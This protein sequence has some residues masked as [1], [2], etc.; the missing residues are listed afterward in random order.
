MR[1]QREV[2]PIPTD[3]GAQLA[4]SRE[5]ITHHAGCDVHWREWAGKGNGTP[6]VALHGGHGS[7]LHWLRNIDTFSTHRRV[8]LPDMPGFGDSGDLALPPRDPARLD[9]LV[10]T[11][12]QGIRDLVGEDMPFHL[13]GFSFGGL[14]AGLIAQRMPQLRSLALLGSAGHGFR[15]A[16]EVAMRNWRDMEGDERAEV[17]RENLE[18]FMLAGPANETACWIHARS[19]ERTNFYSKSYS[20]KALL[21]EALAGVNAP[22][23]MMW[24]ENDV[25]AEPLRAAEHLVQ[26]RMEREWLIIPNAGHWVQYESAERVN[27]LLSYWL[28]R[29]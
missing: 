22:V 8:L 29:H 15:R 28:A 25:T 20:R 17:L 2:L 6:L 4:L 19:C 10:E 18:A 14:V 12:C 11:L 24:G 16:G 13:V 9:L 23:F 7:W 5:R 21:A 3:V 26:G 1:E 27:I